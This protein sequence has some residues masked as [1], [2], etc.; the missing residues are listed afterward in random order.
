VIVITTQRRLTCALLL[1]SAGAQSATDAQRASCVMRPLHRSFPV[2]LQ[3]LTGIKGD[4]LEG[5][6][7]AV[8]PELWVRTP[9][10]TFDLLVAADGPAGSGRYWT[11]TVGLADR[12]A[13]APTRGFCLSAS[14]IGWRTL[15]S[16]PAPL[17]W[18][19][20]RDRDGRP[21]LVLWE[22]FSLGRM[23]PVALTAL[24]AWVYEWD[25]RT[26]FALDV[27]QSRRIAGTIATAYRAPLPA[28]DEF[29]KGLR[30]TAARSLTAFASGACEVR[31][32]R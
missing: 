7:E 5:P 22:N 9:A 16:Y 31:L 14:T 25:G 21:E 3:G 17:E 30:D 18:T 24:V 26:G 29:L 6:C 2:P 13:A 15:Q 12:G 11:I 8:P 28:P 32:P 19:G 27:A 1:V 4:A 10:D 23:E 20:D